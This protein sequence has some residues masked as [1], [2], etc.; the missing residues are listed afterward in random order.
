MSEP[1]DLIF[2]NI[3][4]QIIKKSL[5]TER[6]IQI[7]L[8]QSDLQKSRFSIT[9]GAYFRQVKQSRDKLLALYYSIVLL[10]GLGVLLPEDVELM[11]RLSEQVSVIQG[12]DVFPEKEEEIISVIA[13]LL[14]R[15]CRV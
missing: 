5:F 9:K 12:S 15:A 1:Q 13:E 11:S 8:N 2:N 3:I 14:H 4:K 7:I 10:K 6:Q